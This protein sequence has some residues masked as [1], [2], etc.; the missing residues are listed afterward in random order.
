MDDQQVF[1]W[2]ESQTDSKLS[3]LQQEILKGS[4]ERRSY[5]CI[6]NSCGYQLQYVKDIGYRLWHLLSESCGEIITKKNFPVKIEI[7]INASANTVN[8]YQDWADA[9]DIFSFI[10]RNKDLITLKQWI[11]E[12][13]CRV[14][15][16]MGMGGIGKTQLSVKLGK[17]IEDSFEY[18]IW[19]SLRNPL[20]I[21]DF[22]TDL[23]DFFTNN[24]QTEISH[25]LEIQ[26][27]QLVDFFKQHRCLLILDNIETILKE[28]GYAGQYCQ[29]YEGY[30]QFFRQ[31]GL[32]PHQSCLILTSRE[33]PHDLEQM[34]GIS[35]PVRL[36]E[37]KGLNYS[38][39]K[40]IFQTIGNFTGSD[41][42]WLNLI[43]FYN[44]NPLVLKLV[45]HHIQAVFGGDIAQFIV[46]GKYI[47]DD[48]R[49]VLDRHLER[50]S[51]AEKEI[52]Y[53][54]AN[55]WQPVSLAELKVQ[56]RSL[57]TKKRITNI[58]QSLTRRLVIE[59]SIMGYTLQTMLVEYIN[60]QRNPRLI[61]TS[62][63][64]VARQINFPQLLRAN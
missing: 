56:L 48:L 38:E 25:C 7:I 2:I 32:V 31:I 34:T 8:N 52:I 5:K 17:E 26:I 41:R 45:A 44:G 20:P 47:F 6:A 15:G 51:T 14:V 23:I 28:G 63:N 46:E 10:G 36:L 43:Q 39:G 35:Y 22:L 40:R 18:I 33:K 30:S 55:N 37:L 4:W 58:L 9:P 16:I 27:S 57:D 13:C 62:T 59:T 42:Q 49:Q 53:C 64:L 24:K 19:R 21:T 54:L 29:E 1:D 50:L 61:I 60:Y 3:D 12:D 11:I